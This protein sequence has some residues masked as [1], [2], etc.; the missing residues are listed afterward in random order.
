MAV[1]M[2]RGKDLMPGG[3][4]AATADAEQAASALAWWA[5]AGVDTLVAE[6]PRNWLQIVAHKH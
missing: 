6:T 4:A 1:G 5:E 3:E 2:V